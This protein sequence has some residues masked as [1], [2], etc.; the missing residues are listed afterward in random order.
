MA[1][2]DI[3]GKRLKHVPRT[4]ISKPE[5]TFIECLTSSHTL[6][7][8]HAWEGTIRYWSNADGGWNSSA[9]QWSYLSWHHYHL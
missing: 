5:T 9:A 7:C 1:V 8:T 2:R 3:L 4:P 6:V